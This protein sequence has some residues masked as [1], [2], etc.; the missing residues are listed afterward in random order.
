MLLL[1]RGVGGSTHFSSNALSSWHSLAFLHFQLRWVIWGVAPCQPLR[2]NTGTS[3]S[4]VYCPVSKRLRR[5]L[6]I[7][8]LRRAACD[9]TPFRSIRPLC[10]TGKSPWPKSVARRE[11]E[12]IIRKEKF[13]CETKRRLAVCRVS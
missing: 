7:F 12:R 3:K 2:S 6:R 8:K 1:V 10:V 13:R 9:R 11:E 4:W 5:C